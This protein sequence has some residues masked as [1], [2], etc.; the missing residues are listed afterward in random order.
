MQM[1]QK[2]QDLTGINKFKQALS[3]GLVCYQ[4]KVSELLLKDSYDINTSSITNK[5]KY[6]SGL[7][8]SFTQ[9]KKPVSLE[10]LLYKIE[11]PNLSYG[12]QKLLKYFADTAVIITDN[13]VLEEE[14]MPYHVALLDA[15][16]DYVL[17]YYP[18]NLQAGYYNQ[19]F[20]TI[21]IT[22]KCIGIPI[23]CLVF[24]KDDGSCFGALPCFEQLYLKHKQS[25]NLPVITTSLKQ[26]KQVLEPAQSL[27]IHQVH[28]CR[29]I[30]DYAL[31]NA[32]PILNTKILGS[33][34]GFVILGTVA[35]L[36]GEYEISTNRNKFLNSTA[37]QGGIDSLFDWTDKVVFDYLSY[38]IKPELNSDGSISYQWPKAN[39][40]WQEL[41]K[42]YEVLSLPY[43]TV[44]NDGTA[45]LD[46]STPVISDQKPEML[47]KLFTFFSQQILM[48]MPHLVSEPE[49]TDISDNQIN[50]VKPLI[51]SKGLATLEIGITRGKGHKYYLGKDDIYSF[52]G[53]RQITHWLKMPYA[54]E[55]DSNERK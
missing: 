37:Y 43:L 36:A 3:Q 45:C 18:E 40:F 12:L 15:T 49:V 21:E 52:Y 47:T 8:A 54:K 38:T 11:K 7:F 41:L 20:K 26:I 13:T 23:Q 29:F 48:Q 19:K 31:P 10:Y 44:N 53:D 39:Q 35:Q 28:M 22:Q 27:K 16:A 33:K 17:N 51:N 55:S 5:F 1:M 34:K 6:G 14:Q 25:T 9:I 4:N 30:S 2:I 42:K 24:V 50:A 46:S 32:D